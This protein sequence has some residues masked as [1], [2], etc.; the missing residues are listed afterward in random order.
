MTED[1]ARRSWRAADEKLCVS[2]TATKQRSESMFALFNIVL[3]REAAMAYSL[4]MFRE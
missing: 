2:T 1:G 4:S 3:G